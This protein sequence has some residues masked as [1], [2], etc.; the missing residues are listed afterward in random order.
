MYYCLKI[1]DKN[2]YCKKFLGLIHFNTTECYYLKSGVGGALYYCLKSE[3]KNYYCKK[4][5]SLIRFNTM[6]CYYLK[7][8]LLAWAGCV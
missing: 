8:H 7:V 5:L 2:Y 1:E 6:E 3:D 4:F